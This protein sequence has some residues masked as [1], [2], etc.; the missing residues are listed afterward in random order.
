[1]EGLLYSKGE[2]QVKYVGPGQ[3]DDL[4]FV[5]E[6]EEPVEEGPDEVASDSGELLP[7]KAASHVLRVVEQHLG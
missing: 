4:H 1:M 2:N 5:V 3:T 7:H 6:D